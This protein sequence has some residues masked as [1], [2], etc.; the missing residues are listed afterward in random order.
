M[1]SDYVDVLL[2]K[3]MLAWLKYNSKEFLFNMRCIE[4]EESSNRSWI[5]TNNSLKK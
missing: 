5:G 3:M 1:N 2:M 4:N